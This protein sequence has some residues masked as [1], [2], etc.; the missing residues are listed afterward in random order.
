[1]FK[2]INKYYRITTRLALTLPITPKRLVDSA[3]VDCPFCIMTDNKA[4]LPQNHTRNRS[5]H[6]FI[7]KPDILF[8]DIVLNALITSDLCSD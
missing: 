4:L 6:A 1:M 8:V 5:Q 7:F 3:Q 2:I